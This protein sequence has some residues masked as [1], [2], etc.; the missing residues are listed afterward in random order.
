MAIDLVFRIVGHQRGDGEFG[1]ADIGDSGG[2]LEIAAAEDPFGGDSSGEGVRCFSF[3]CE[4]G[5]PG[6]SVAVKWFEFGNGGELSVRGER[7][8]GEEEGHE[9]GGWFHKGR[10]TGIRGSVRF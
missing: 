10:L 1:I 4:G 2:L 7:E 6:A 5:G 3:E 9:D 8:E